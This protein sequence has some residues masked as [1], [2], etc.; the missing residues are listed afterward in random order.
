M[1]SLAVGITY[2][3]V[4]GLSALAVG[5]IGSSALRA[6][7]RNPEAANELRTLMILAISFADA[8]AIIGFVAALILKFLK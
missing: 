1:E 7:G 2:T 5:M 3:F 8:L 6:V 4:G